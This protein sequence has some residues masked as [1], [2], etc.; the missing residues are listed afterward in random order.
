MGTGC[1]AVQRT[2]TADGKIEVIGDWGHGRKGIYREAKEFHGRAK[3]TK[4]EAPA[5]G[6]DGYVPLV[7]QIMVF[8]KT[9]VAPVTPAETI[10]IFAFMEAADLSKARGGTT[11]KIRE[12]LKPK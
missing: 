3:G 2:N 6:F 4:G 11:V 10:E 7:E 5:G 8:F 12:V 1:L 9:G